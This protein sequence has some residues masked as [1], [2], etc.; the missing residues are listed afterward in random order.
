VE[1]GWR[2]ERN[3]NEFAEK[4]VR[5]GVTLTGWEQ[6]SRRRPPVDDDDW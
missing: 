2:G 1:Y 4:V 6:W 3:V 5:F